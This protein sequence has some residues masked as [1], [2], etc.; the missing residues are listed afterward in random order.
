MGYIYAAPTI[1]ALL[2]YILTLL[3]SDSIVLFLAR[4]NNLTYE[5]EFRIILVIPVFLTGIPGLIAYGY[6]TTT[7]G[8]HWIVPS[9]LYGMLTF[10]VIVSCIVTYSYLLDAHREVSV[11][12][13]V[14]VLLLK[15]FFAWGSTY[16]LPNWIV[17]WGPRK[18]F[19]TMGCI[20]GAICLGSV[21]VWVWGKVWREKMERVQLL[22]RLGL[23]PGKMRTE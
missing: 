17:Q 9:I 23:K 13:M 8:L 6:A 15:N 3:T 10:A 5:P 18:V 22:K 20:Q 21:V 7:P 11:E 16:Y 2:A 14:A 19:L 12:M 1:G 4:R